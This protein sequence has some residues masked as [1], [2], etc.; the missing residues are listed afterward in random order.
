MPLEILHGPLML[1]RGLAVGKGAEV[2]AFS[3]FGIQFAGE[4]TI[5]SGFKF[6]NHGRVLG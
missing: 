2:A 6:A 5:L 4:E 1:F 3:G